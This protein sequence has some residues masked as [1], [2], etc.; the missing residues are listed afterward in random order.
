MRKKKNTAR[1]RGVSSRGRRNT[2]V[3][4]SN[5]LLLGVVIFLLVTSFIASLWYIIDT[6]VINKRTASNFSKLSFE[7]SLTYLGNHCTGVCSLVAD[8]EGQYL[9]EYNGDLLVSGDFDSGGHHL[10]NKKEKSVSI[11][12]GKYLV[13][14]ESYDSYTGRAQTDPDM[15]REEQ[16]YVDFMNGSTRIARTPTTD[17]LPDGLE[18]VDKIYLV[19]G[20]NNPLSLNSPVNKVVIN[21]AGTYVPAGQ[22]GALNGFE[23]VCM[24]LERINDCGNGVKESGEECDDG[25]TVNGDGC[26]STCQK[27]EDEPDCGNGVKE[28]GEECDDGNTVNG[29]GCSSTCQKEED[30]PDCDSSIGNY[31]WYDVDGDGNQ[32]SIEE[33]ISG[34]KVCAE[35]GNKKYCDRTDKKGRYKI[36][37]LCEGKYT[38][39]VRGVSDL[40]QTYDPDGKKDSKTT[41]KLKKNDKHTKADFGYRAKAPKTGVVTD[42]LLLVLI[43]T[44]IT[45]GVLVI[46]KNKGTI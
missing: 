32:D 8:R 30:E 46:M 14:L 25:N 10:T 3:S 18:D 35:K 1:K 34:V 4:S 24:L 38:V 11:P 36:D 19:N 41:V 27:E 31:I 37:N 9:V 7:N 28:S 13:R 21:H 40:D 33:G 26:S 29:D 45:V 2:R 43:S 44:F 15:Q 39:K 23:P 20:P 22:S 5:L 16:Y 42:V 17:D 12:P 6:T